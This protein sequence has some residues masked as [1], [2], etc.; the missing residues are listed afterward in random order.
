M[1][2]VT[3]LD[4]LQMAFFSFGARDHDLA[5]IKVPDDQPLG[6]SGLAHSAFE[7]EGESEQLRELYG[8]LKE[9][10]VE[11]E[12]SADHVVTRSLYFLDPDGNRLEFYAQVLPTAEAKQYLH[13]ATSAADVLRPL[14][15]EALVG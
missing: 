7:I 9:R 6:S 4:D 12:M 13:G 2:L 3:F 11:V 10:G 8:A 5:V 15:M 1:E 14:D